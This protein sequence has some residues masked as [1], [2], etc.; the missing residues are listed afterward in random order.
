[1]TVNIL[2]LRF[3]LSYSVEIGDRNVCSQSRIVQICSRAHYH[4]INH[5][6]NSCLEKNQAWNCLP[7]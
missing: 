4:E 3:V 5:S 2:G 1:M 7:L 6:S